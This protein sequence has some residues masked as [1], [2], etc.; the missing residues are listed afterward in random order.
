MKRLRVV[1]ALLAIAPT[2]AVVVGQV[3]DSPL[4]VPGTE[5][6]WES[7]KLNLVLRV[8]EKTQ[9][10]LSV[11]SPGFDP[12]DYRSPNELGDER[13]DQSDAPLKTLIRIFDDQGQVRLRRE[14][15]VEPHRWHKLMDGALA[16]GDYLIEIEFFGNGKNAL[17]FKLEAD[18]ARAKLEI[19]PGS[20]QTYNVHGE[21]LRFPFSVE[22][23]DWSAPI[24]VGIYD[25]DGPEELL[26]RVQKPGGSDQSLP[27]PGNG[28]WVRYR[29]DEAGTYRFGFSQPKTAKQYT[30]TVGFKVF[31]GPVK[32]HVVDEQGS[33]VKGA[34]YKIT[35][36]YDRAVSLSRVPDGWE[37]VKTESE[38]G[39][40]ISQKRVLFGPGGGAVT[41]V[42]RRPVGEAVVSASV[43]CDGQSWPVPLTLQIGDKKVALS[44]AGT[45]L[46]GLPAGE[47]PVKVDVAGATVEAPAKVRVVPGKTSNL[48]ISLQPQL[49]TELQLE[50]DTVAVGNGVVARARVSTAFPY[51]LPAELRL[52]LP[53]GVS[54]DGNPAVSGPLSA[55]RP[56]TLSA[57]LSSEEVGEYQIKAVATPC[58]ATA[59]ATLKAL[60]PA[61]ITVTKQAV[62]PRIRLGDVAR[63][64]ISL[65]NHGQQSGRVRV[66]DKLP[67][68]IRGKGL[69]EYVVLNPGETRRFEVSGKTT[70]AGELVNTVRV[71]DEQGRLAG[72][73]RAG[74]TVE[75]AQVALTRSLDKRVVVPGET[76]EVC[77]QV[78][79]PGSLPV[80]Y[81]LTDSYPDWLEPE[82]SPS[83]AGE[84]D[85]GQQ[86]E[87][88]Y[89]AKVRFGS[90][91]QGR[92]TAS[93][94][95]DAGAPKATDEI[96]RV[97]LGLAKTAIPQR[98]L[99]GEEAVFKVTLSNPTD[100]ALSV[101]LLDT[102]AAGLGMQQVEEVVELAAS[103]LRTFEYTAKPDKTGSLENKVSAYVNGSPAAF[104]AKASLEV[105]PPLQPRRI[106]EI[107][108]PFQVDGAGGGL[109][110]AHQ[111]PAGAAYQPGSS[112]LDGKPIPEPRVSKEGRLIWKIPYQKQGVLTYAVEHEKALP[113]LGQPD[114]TLLAGDRELPLVGGVSLEDYRRA[115]PIERGSRQGMIREP[116]P[117]T[118]YSQADSTKVV[119]VAPYG[120]EVKLTVNGVPVGEDRLGEAQYDAQAG[121]QKLNYYAV[122]L[123]AGRNLI[124]V[125]AGGRHDEVEVFRAGRPER[126]QVVPVEAVA[127]GRTPIRL[128]IE[129]MDAAGLASGMGF[130]TVESS[131]EPMIADANLHESGYQVLLEN[132]AAE[133]VLWPLVTPGEV[134]IKMLKDQLVYTSRIYVPGPADTLWTAQG[135]ITV[136]YNGTVEVGG[137]ARGYIETPLAGGTLQGAVGV[138]GRVDAG[139]VY[140]QPGLSNRHGPTKRFPLAGSGSG[141]KLPL[142]SDDGVAFK[143]DRNNF[144]VGYYK[145]SLSL[146]GVSGLPR[147]TALVLQTRGDL[148]AGAFVT[149]LPSSMVADEIVPDGTSIYRLSHAVK[150][151][152][153][154]VVLRAGSVETELVPLRDYV[155][156]YPSGHITLSRSLWPTDEGA[157]PV[158]LLVEY[159]P[160]D[161]PRDTLAYGAGVRYKLGAF[162]FGAAAATLDR[163]TT[164]KFGA[165]LAYQTQAFNI[166]L[167][168]TLDG[169][170]SVVGLSAAGREGG[171]EV[172][173][174]LRYD[175]T[176]QGKL[177]VAA[178][179]G[180]GGKVAVEHRGSSTS[181]RSALLYEHRIGSISGGLGVGYEWNTTSF[182]ALG[183]LGYS[184]GGL[185][186]TA[187]HRQ[188]FSV[189]PSLSTLNV[190]YAFDANLKGEGELAYEWGTGLSGSFGLKQRLGPA[191]LSIS[192]ALPNASGSGNRA[193]FGIRA[194]LPLSDK[195]TLD[196]SAGYD[197][198]LDSGDYQAAA[199]VG[200]RY[201]TDDLTATVGVEGALSGSGSKVTLRTGAAGKLDDRQTVSFDANYVFAGEPH[202]R[203]TLAYAYRGRALQVLTY[204]R[205][206]NEGGT[207]LE[208]ELAPTWHPSLS[209]QLR[210]SGAYRVS[211]SD[212][213]A[214]LYQIGLGANYHFTSYLGIGGGVYYLWQPALSNLATAFSIEGSLRVID[215]VWLN[216]GYTF[217]GFTGLTPEARPGVYLRLDLMEAEQGGSR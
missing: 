200:L 131:V 186:L 93:L 37:L 111:P 15:G 7:A 152:S 216:V 161:S 138:G 78:S 75:Q 154:K 159:A 102:P 201:K 192:Y 45:A 214:S 148:E 126:L 157:V 58:A 191:N 28:A 205:L 5:L 168:Y 166:A 80:S 137:Q 59:V 110:I 208:G 42:L 29:L 193:R 53:A 44:E 84:L 101:R 48:N 89:A 27:T 20:M 54:A 158:R 146:L 147:A 215:P 79:N 189:A 176:L 177:R 153:E 109:L 47:Y 46:V 204:H 117:G 63:F 202:G 62:E 118:V 38:Y 65:E 185:K 4:V 92:F 81:R 150:P 35:G 195:L 128:R 217:G 56:L 100:H 64:V 182:S 95:S 203:F 181:N 32:V 17:A 12:Q 197:R 74:V 198:S 66:V 88:C 136:R 119:V 114:L 77:L 160:A 169:G 60:R 162:S 57:R 143:Y 167:R 174:N 178:K 124:A 16:P 115:K 86:R 121:V 9:V 87:H 39:M 183:R 31:L 213:A 71:F 199:G 135:S 73:A 155:I 210:P 127:D 172:S 76:V 171:I 139:A 107:K 105:L 106:S 19:T 173:G 96:R 194:P 212:P 30:N 21:K 149:L 83:F 209:F 122:P 164:W 129:S 211:L 14:F 207:S 108:L 130:V 34:E 2:L 142:E 123:Q 188:S 8:A 61:Q 52:E 125:D 206:I 82:G 6:G 170:N 97:P 187:T 10:K 151:G 41:Y 72:E 144:S 36:Y 140:V 104:P 26:V 180:E 13:Y 91:V 113:M 33:P 190:S 120:A 141:S 11:F 67:A 98:V 156:D 69:D 90:A 68:G 132:G 99:V 50:S 133:L 23:R 134:T 18:P 43:R 40:P 22:K 179:V 85:P 116:L 25:G 94:T 55:T 70:K 24:T 103:E 145:T 163:G 1:L 112:R 196:L 49:K 184:A 3:N 175:G 51:D 165:E